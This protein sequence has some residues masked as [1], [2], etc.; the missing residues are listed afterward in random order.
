V[1]DT[2]RRLVALAVLTIAAVLAAGCGARFD[3]Q[4]SLRAGNDGLTAGEGGS[5]V[6]VGE[7][8]G[9]DVTTDTTTAGDGGSTG[10]TL[11]GGTGGG[12]SVP[13]TA[14]AIDPGPTTGITDTEIRIGYLV[15]ITGA[16]PVPSQ[17]NKGVEA[18]Y[19][20]VNDRGGINGRKIKVI[21][22]DTTSSASVGKTRAQKLI[23]Q[24]KVFAVVVLDRLENQKAIGEYLESRNV[25]NI[26]VQTPPDLARSSAR[27]T[28]GITIDHAVQG[29]LIADYMVKAL[30][31]QKVAVIQEN[32]PI[33]DPGRKAFTDQVKSLGAQ[34]VLERSIDGQGNDYSSEALALNQ[35]GAT[36]TW[37]YMA[38]TPA[39]KLTNQADALGY[40][41]T[42]FANSISWGFDLIFKVAPKALAGARAFSP[43]LPIS[44]ART[45]TYQDAY[46]AQYNET[47]DDIGIIGWGVGQIVVEGMRRAGPQL[48]QNSYRNALQNLQFRPDVWAPMNFRPGVRQGGNVIAVLKEQ[49]GVWALERDFT[50]R[51]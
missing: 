17:F 38:P 44:D 23:E 12:P 16:A 48:G 2:R 26:E 20:Y 18:Y 5:D 24:D 22:E 41:P 32:T 9:E 21:V 31:A 3:E 49:G 33:L 36:A 1:G 45:K 35:S 4:E 6:G 39:A 29:R 51:F 8:D 15:P 43:W 10:S 14:G 28:F 40:H 46:R 34:V 50:D 7:G 11:V 42:W 47:P 27:W 30:K 19:K 25:P 37:L 13:T